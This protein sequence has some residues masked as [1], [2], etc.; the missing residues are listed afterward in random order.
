MQ[1][2]NGAAYHDVIS[3]ISSASRRPAFTFAGHHSQVIERNSFFLAILG[4]A[5]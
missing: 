2:P 5:A 4:D 3:R 1:F